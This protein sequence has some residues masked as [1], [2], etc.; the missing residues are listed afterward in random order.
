MIISVV[1]PGSP[2]TINTLFNS[3]NY[4]AIKDEPAVFTK[5]L[6]TKTKPETI[7]KP[8]G[9]ER[10]YL[11]YGFVNEIDPKDAPALQVL[12]LILSDNIVFDIREK[13][14]MAYNM[15]AGI[16]VVKDKALFYINQ[17]TRPQNVDILVPQYPGFFGMKSVDT[18]TQNIVE[19]SI[20]MYLGRMMFRRLSSI[21]QAFYLGS[22]EYFFQ[23]Y[24]RDKNFLDALKNIKLADVQAV[25][26]KY[27]NI[28]NPMTLIVR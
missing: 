28:N 15:S 6:L 13:Q 18:L 17:G 11:F 24:M 19:K 1:S 12:S 14:G 21:N 25:A 26:K 3:L 5:T 20:N 8:G 10:S 7:D 2:E 9:G 22:S 4:T 23:D 27:M 16:E